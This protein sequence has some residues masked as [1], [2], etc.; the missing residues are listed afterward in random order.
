MT[1]IFGWY[2]LRNICVYIYNTYIFALGENNPPG[3]KPTSNPGSLAAKR[4][5]EIMRFTLFLFRFV[6]KMTVIPL[7]IALWEWQQGL[8]QNSAKKHIFVLPLWFWWNRPRHFYNAFWPFGLGIVQW[9]PSKDHQ[10]FGFPSATG[11]IQLRR[12]WSFAN[13]LLWNR[14]FQQVPN[15]IYGACVLG[16]KIHTAYAIHASKQHHRRCP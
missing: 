14:C 11:C 5:I 13:Q 3:W 1:L 6:R 15:S 2:T 12:L 8:A 10:L 7:W 16:A 9:L 4:H